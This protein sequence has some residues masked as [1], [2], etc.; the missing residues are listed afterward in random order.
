MLT[1]KDSLNDHDTQFSS[2][3]HV[4]LDLPFFI[5]NI[6]WQYRTQELLSGPQKYLKDFSFKFTKF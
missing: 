2:E 5:G 4:N 1:L 6:M 3:S